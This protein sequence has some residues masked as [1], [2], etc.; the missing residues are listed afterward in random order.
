VASIF[1][2]PEHNGLSRVCH[3][4][5]HDDYNNRLQQSLKRGL[6][7]R[8]HLTQRRLAVNKNTSHKACIKGGKHSACNKGDNWIVTPPEAGSF[9]LGSAG[10]G[11]L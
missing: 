2:T 7:Q 11:C 1:H 3:T 10:P 6:Q 5:T 9:P 8:H 4:L